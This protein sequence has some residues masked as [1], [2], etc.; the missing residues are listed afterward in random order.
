M[1]QLFLRLQDNEKRLS[2]Q[3]DLA[4][5]NAQ[6]RDASER[7]CQQLQAQLAEAERTKQ[8]VSLLHKQKE[9]AI[10]KLTSSEKKT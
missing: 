5:K 7:R 1:A 10:H 2:E 6:Q 8:Q 9:I 3:R 4:I